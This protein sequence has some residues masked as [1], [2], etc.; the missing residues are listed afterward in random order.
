MLDDILNNPHLLAGFGTTLFVLLVLIFCLLR[1]SK[2]YR[3]R[4]DQL[5][6]ENRTLAKDLQKSGKQIVELRSIAVGLGQSFS[7]QQDVMRLLA[8]RISELEQEDK[9]GRLY[10][11]ATKMVKLGADIDEL[12]EECELPKAEAELML[13]LQKKLAGHEKI[14][15]LEQNPSERQVTSSKRSTKPSR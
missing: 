14:P 15:P 5:R 9:D 4:F 3:A 7:E 10:S 2:N 6:Q 8:E 1:M 12:I 13:S 11:R